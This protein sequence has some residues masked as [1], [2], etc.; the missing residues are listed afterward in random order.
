[1][2]ARSDIAETVKAML[3][4]GIPEVQG[5]VYRTRL[6]PTDPRHWPCLLVVLDREQVDTKGGI[7]GRRVQSRE[8]TLSVFFV[9][10]AL[11]EDLEDHLEA[12]ND[13]IEAVFASDWL[14]RNGG[15][16]KVSDLRIASTVA[17][18]SPQGSQAVGVLRK[19]FR[20]EY[21]TTESNPGQALAR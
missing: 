5:R 16:P 18:I 21:H 3:E 4:A 13:R 19:D 8:L 2:S 9:D 1:M 15:L 12:F 20:L 7:P 11:R 17:T 14:L 10:S 6:L